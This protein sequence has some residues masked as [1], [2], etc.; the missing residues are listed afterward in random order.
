MTDLSQLIEPD[1]KQDAIDRKPSARFN[2]DAYVQCEDNQIVPLQCSLIAM[3]K[4]MSIQNKIN[5]IMRYIKERQGLYGLV[6]ELV[7]PTA[8]RI[9]FHCIVDKQNAVDEAIKEITDEYTADLLFSVC[10][11]SKQQYKEYLKRWR[12][13]NIKK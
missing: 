3:D 2:S 9:L 6:N 12:K 5:G 1:Y 7:K 11:S 13:T 8:V 4:N 10:C